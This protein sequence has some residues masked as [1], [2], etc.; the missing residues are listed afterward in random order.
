[1]VCKQS[2]SNLLKTEMISTCRSPKYSDLEKKL[3]H[4]AI[5]FS[6]VDLIH[7][8]QNTVPQQ[9]PLNTAVNMHILL[10]IGNSLTSSMAFT[11]QVGFCCT[12]LV[13]LD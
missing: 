1:M 3:C 2:T 9:T 12:E 7:V 4:L 13:H 10:I 8:T 11:F 6:D 5:T